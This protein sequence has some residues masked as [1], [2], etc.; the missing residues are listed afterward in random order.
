[1]GDVPTLLHLLNFGLLSGSVERRPC[2]SVH[3]NSSA[4][5]PT[6]TCLTQIP[7]NVTLG[8]AKF[9]P[10]MPSAR[11]EFLSRYFSGKKKQHQLKKHLTN[12]PG[13]SPSCL[14]LPTVQIAKNPHPGGSEERVPDDALPLWPVAAMRP[15]KPWPSAPCSPPLCP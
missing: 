15:P 9:S 13:R 11:L 7:T 4:R 2:E 1:M 10:P 5:I 3:V 14:C 12:S 6:R 8:M